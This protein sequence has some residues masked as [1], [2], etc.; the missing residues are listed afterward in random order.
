[1]RGPFACW[2]ARITLAVAGRAKR[3]AL[4]VPAIRQTLRARGPMLMLLVVGLHFLWDVLQKPNGIYLRL[5]VSRLA[6]FLPTCG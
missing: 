5:S 3:G 1:M 2:A 6:I 4:G